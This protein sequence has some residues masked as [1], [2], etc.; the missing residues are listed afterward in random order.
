MAVWGRIA[1]LALVLSIAGSAVTVSVA[2]GYTEHDETK[3]STSFAEILS[4]SDGFAGD[5]FGIAVD[6]D[7]DVMVVGAFGAAYVFTRSNRQWSET[8]KLT[9]PNEPLGWDPIRVP[10]KSPED[11]PVEGLGIRIDDS[12][13]VYGGFG[14][15]VA[16]D[17]DVIVVGAY[18]A[19][20]VY[21]AV[22]GQWVGTAKLT[23]PDDLSGLGPNPDGSHTIGRSSFDRFLEGGFGSSV[24]LDGDVIAVGANGVV[25][26]PEGS[27]GTTPS[28][29]E[30]LDSVY[31]FTRHEDNWRE[32]ARLVR[33]DGLRSYD[34]GTDL[35]VSGNVLVVGSHS[36]AFVYERSG[37]EWSEPTE[38]FPVDRNS[39]FGFGQS[40][41]AS[42]DF[43]AVSSRHGVHVFE[44][45]FGVWVGEILEPFFDPD[46]YRF[47]LDVDLD[48]NLM[49]LT[50]RKDIAGSEMTPIVFS[51]FDRPRA[52]WRVTGTSSYGSKAWKVQSV[53]IGGGVIAL[54]AHLSTYEAGED[55]VWRTTHKEPGVVHTYNLQVLT[56]AEGGVAPAETP[57]GST[58]EEQPTAIAEPAATPLAVTTPTAAETPT[59]TAVITPAVTPIPTEMAAASPVLINDDSTDGGTNAVWAGVIIAQLALIVLAVAYFAI[60]RKPSDDAGRYNT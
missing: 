37:D 41:A 18:E 57:V 27:S 19:A 56:P 10:E 38:L 21:T 3:T 15:S 49:V 42:A 20:Y 52:D 12:G 47:G 59:G 13:T 23:G 39:R 17:G 6:V 36:A 9:V 35:D 16:V 2:A 14:R 11:E 48:S 1:G 24:A 46:Y 51:L 26:L 4:A 54:G 55:L 33:P 58:A 22:E 30:N 25:R 53:A 32:T 31:V 43:I 40:V 5:G 34:F 8:V 28:G 7:G 60:R 44:R 50:P 29:V 45:S